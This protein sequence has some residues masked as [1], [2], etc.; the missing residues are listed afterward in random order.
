M[1]LSLFFL[2]PVGDLD[3]VLPGSGTHHEYALS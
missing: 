2:G 3:E 1:E